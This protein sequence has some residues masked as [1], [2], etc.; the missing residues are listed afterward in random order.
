MPTFNAYQVNY[1]NSDLLFEA[2]SLVTLS[3]TPSDVFPSEKQD[4]YSVDIAL[5]GLVRNEN[6]AS[7]SELD[8]VATNIS[9]SGKVNITVPDLPLLQN[10]S[11]YLTVTFQVRFSPLSLTNQSYDQ[12]SV[13]AGIWTSEAYYSYEGEPSRDRCIAWASHLQ[14]RETELSQISDLPACPCNL[15]Q[16]KAPNSGFMEE[17]GKDIFQSQS[18]VCYYQSTPIKT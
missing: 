3:W 2:S 8:Q 1:L 11:A 10:H 7:W 16:A 17:Q 13:S 4:S 5:Y 12:L 15:D 18:S 6:T 9:N 14:A